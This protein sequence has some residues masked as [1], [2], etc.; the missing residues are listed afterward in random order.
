MFILAASLT[1]FW[2][3]PWPS[4]PWS[5]SWAENDCVLE[6]TEFVI[7]LTIAMP[8]SWL[9]LCPWVDYCVFKLTIA[10]S[11]SSVLELT[12][13][14]SLTWLA[15]TLSRLWLRPWGDN[16]YIFQVTVTVCLCWLIPC[17]WDDEWWRDRIEG[18]LV[19]ELL[20]NGYLGE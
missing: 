12:T 14:V 20:V 10:V 17:Q 11:L 1:W 8:L 4:W 18:N 15:V 13:T 2:M 16:I 5:Y 6:L 7:N 19:F 9:R 3:Y